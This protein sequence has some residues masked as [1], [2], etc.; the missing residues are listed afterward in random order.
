MIFQ[1]D[2]TRPEPRSVL[3]VPPSEPGEGSLLRIQGDP[4]DII[5]DGV[6]RSVMMQE[7]GLNQV[8]VSTLG[9]EVADD[10]RDVERL[11]EWLRS[12]GDVGI[13]VI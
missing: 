4:N 6:V 9:I 7:R 11:A 13:M 3:D 5:F 12:G 2:Y 10:H 8:P 1:F